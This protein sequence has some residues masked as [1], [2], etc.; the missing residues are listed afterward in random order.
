M[1]LR[2]LKGPLRPGKSPFFLEGSE[3]HGLCEAEG[4]HA[5]YHFDL[6][7]FRSNPA[8][9]RPANRVLEVRRA[10]GLLRLIYERGGAAQG[11]R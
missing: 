3:A 1:A 7:L 10:G 8:L 9:P 2:G 6:R 11:N 4:I 5:R